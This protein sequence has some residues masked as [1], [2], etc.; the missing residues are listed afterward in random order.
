[1]TNHITATL[2]QD[3]PTCINGAPYWR[4]DGH[5]INTPIAQ[6]AR[7]ANGRCD[8]SGNGPHTIILEIADANYAEAV[9]KSRRMTLGEVDSLT[10]QVA[11]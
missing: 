10:Q 11:A 5:F 6:V 7:W 2:I 3:H 1:M 4:V 8:E 9:A